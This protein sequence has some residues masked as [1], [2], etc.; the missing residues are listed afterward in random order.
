LN[1]TVSRTVAGVPSGAISFSNFYGKS[2]KKAMFW[3]GYFTSGKSTTYVNSCTR[4][5]YLGATIGGADTSVA[6]A[7]TSHSGAEC[8]ENGLFYGGY[9]PVS[10]SGNWI[11]CTRINSSG[12][13]VGSQTTVGTAGKSEHAGAPVGGNGLFYAGLNNASVAVNTILRINSSG[14]IVGTE[15]TAGTARR[16]LAG[17]PV[18]GNGLFYAGG[19]ATTL[20]TR[21]NSTGALVGVE[22]NVSTGRN[23]P[24]GATPSSGNGMFFGGINSGSTV[25]NQ[26]VRIDTNGAIVGTVTTAGTARYFVSGATAGEYGLYCAGINSSGTES[27]LAT[28]ID[29]NGAIVG[30]EFSP[31][32]SF[33]ERG[34]SSY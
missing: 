30:S 3:G 10:G 32:G 18:G 26:V 20:V 7:R 25:T 22:T 15:T 8:G 5:D 31:S 14:A 11:D 1:D 24:G 27:G 13:L 23:N 33:T 19:S 34:G 16:D 2:W 28:R 12:A 29:S 6:T 4:I 17:A 9:P 21:I